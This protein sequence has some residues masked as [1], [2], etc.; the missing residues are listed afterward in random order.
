MAKKKQSK[1]TPKHYGSAAVKTDPPTTPATVRP[2]ELPVPVREVLAAIAGQATREHPQG[3]LVSRLAA[4][5][6]RC[7]ALLEMDPD[8]TAEA[9]QVLRALQAWAQSCLEGVEEAF[10]AAG[11]PVAQDKGGDDGAE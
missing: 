10:S 7:T 3:G 5:K 1:S 9:F 2:E 11:F 8:S 6:H 4:V